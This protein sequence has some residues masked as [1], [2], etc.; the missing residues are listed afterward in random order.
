M[1]V[2]DYLSDVLILFSTIHETETRVVSELLVT[3]IEAEWSRVFH[4][5]CWGELEG[6]DIAEASHVEKLERAMRII[7]ADFTCGV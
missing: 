3:E 6:T 5:K 7:E 2:N 1:T 4:D